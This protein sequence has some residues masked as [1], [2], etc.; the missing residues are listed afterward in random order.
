[1]EINKML[2]VLKNVLNMGS[3]GEVASYLQEAAEKM[4]LT[5]D[6]LQNT[7]NLVLFKT[8]YLE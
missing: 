4:Q 3:E 8:D 7:A 6:R 2:K 5:I 1:M